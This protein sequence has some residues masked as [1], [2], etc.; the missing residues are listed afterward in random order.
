VFVGH[1]AAGLLA[2]PLAPRVPLPVLLAAPQVLDIA[3]PVL[4]GAGVERARVEPGHLEAAPL[5][6]EHMPWSHSLLTACGWA[7]L[8]ALAYLAWRRDRR[9][10]VVVAVLVLSHWLLDWVTHEPDMPLYPGSARHGLGLW[11]SLPATLAVELAMF[12]AGVWLY[13]R[14]TTPTGR[15]GRTGWHAL[16]GFLLVAYVAAL[17]GKPPP[18][19]TA[20]VITA[21]VLIVL[22]LAWSWAVDRQRPPRASA[23]R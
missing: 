8:S 2:K 6:L 17:F 4:V 1:F 19:I 10:A 14:A 21:F 18:T 11:N 5:V 13:T 9:G 16:V 15:W 3:W 23:T 22:V 12:A 20:V 7:L